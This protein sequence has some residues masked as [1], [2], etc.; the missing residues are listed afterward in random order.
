MQSLIGYR[1]VIIAL[2]GAI[3]VVFGAVWMT[4]L[5]PAMSKAPTDLDE[6]VVLE[7]TY[8]VA[9]SQ[10]GQ[11]K[12]RPV[13]VERVSKAVDTGSNNAVIVEETITTTNSATGEDITALFGSTEPNMLAVDRSTLAMMP[14]A[15]GADMARQG[16]W[17]PPMG[18][19]EGST[20]Q[21]WNPAA[22]QALTA[23]W[24]GT[25]TLGG[26]DVAIFQISEE[27]LALGP[28][29]I[30]LPTGGSMMLDKFVSTEITLWVEPATGVVVNSE[31]DL[32]VAFEVPGMGMMPSF[33]SDLSYTDGTV[34]YYA[35]K[36]STAASQLFVFGTLLPWT[37]IG[38]GAVLL[39]IPVDLI[40]YRRVFRK[41]PGAREVPAPTSFS[42]DR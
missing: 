22:G 5:L 10:T 42:I 8:Q 29:E 12:S 33:I 1:K 7:G 27:N 2:A 4:A 35:D 15:E 28:E 39:L 36:A 11:L 3:L 38:V 25:D 18:L 24:T 9:D 19:S 40:I 41:A 16:Q 21:M 6:T 20:F 30:T 13:T 32:T 17:S 14:D 23:Q 26:V 31:S 37:F 34:A